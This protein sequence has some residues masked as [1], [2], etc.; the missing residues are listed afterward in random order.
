MLRILSGN[1][2][3]DAAAAVDLLEE[4]AAEPG[5]AFEPVG[6]VE[7][8]GLFVF[9]NLFWVGDLVQVLAERRLVEHRVALDGHQ[10]AV[11]PDLRRLPLEHVQVAG[12]LLADE[13]E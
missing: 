2:P 4:V 12:L 11:D 8:A 13:Q 5:D 1:L 3:E 9:F 7:V 6:E 10:V